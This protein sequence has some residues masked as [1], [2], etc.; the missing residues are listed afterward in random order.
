MTL[1]A[2]TTHAERLGNKQPNLAAT[3]SEGFP[4][5]NTSTGIQWR[6]TYWHKRTLPRLC[7]S[8]GHAN[9][10]GLSTADC[11][12]QSIVAAKKKSKAIGFLEGGSYKKKQYGGLWSKLESTSPAGKTTTLPT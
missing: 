2:T 11:L 7:P 10:P 12:K 4:M 3:V 8:P 5:P 1:G 6:R 9:T